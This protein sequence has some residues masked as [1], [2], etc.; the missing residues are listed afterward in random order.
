[1]E[2]EQE[3]HAGGSDFI[4]FID[5]I[6]R[7]DGGGG[8]KRPPTVRDES[9]PRPRAR[10]HTGAASARDDDTRLDREHRAMR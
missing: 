4:D 1:V 5:F 10:M 8:K 6:G 3:D 2:P 9:S 7:G